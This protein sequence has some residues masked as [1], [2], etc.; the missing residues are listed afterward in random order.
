MNI[1]VN[2]PTGQ[3]EII[4]VGKG[5]GYFDTSRSIWDERDDG[6]MPEITLG[7]M[8]RVDDALEIDSGMLAQLLPRKKAELITEVSTIAK[9]KRNAGVTINGLHIAT[10]PDGR[11]LLFGAIQGGKASRKIVTKTGRAVLTK[12]QIEALATAV[13]NYLQAVFDNQYDLE[14]AIEA[15]ADQAALDAIDINAGWPV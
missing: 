4:G 14:E 12:V 9:Q 8:I 5:G 7:A 3:Q 1:L 15:A 6:P 10:G 11:S 2:A 13:D